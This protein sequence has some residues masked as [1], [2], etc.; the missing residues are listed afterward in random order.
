MLANDRLYAICIYD[1]TKENPQELEANVNDKLSLLCKVN[2]DWILAKNQRTKETGVIPVSFVSIKQ[3]D[4][5]KHIVSSGADLVSLREWKHRNSNQIQELL[6]RN[7]VSNPANTIPN[8]K[9]ERGARSLNDLTKNSKDHTS[10]GQFLISGGKVVS[11]EKLKDNQIEYIVH[12]TVNGQNLTLYRQ[13]DDF[14]YMHLAL[15]SAF[16][17]ERDS[18]RKL[19]LLPVPNQNLT[20]YALDRRLDDIDTYIRKLIKLEHL[21]NSKYVQDFFKLQ[22]GDEQSEQ[23]IK[24]QILSKVQSVA[25]RTTKNALSYESLQNRVRD[26]LRVETFELR[27]RFT[28]KRIRCTNDLISIVEANPEK[29]VLYIPQK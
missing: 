18:N 1:F 12:C 25:F 3:K 9:L 6:T 14:F 26:K 16:P 15:K 27:D 17:Q 4:H 22:P 23:T 8:K 11:Y 13:Y 29:I 10:K 21:C 19:P 5:P 2:S 20:E 7:A 28:K 24:I